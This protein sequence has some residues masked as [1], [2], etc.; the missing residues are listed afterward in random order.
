[1]AT[2]FLTPDFDVDFIIGMWAVAFFRIESF[3]CG[4]ADEMP[5]QGVQVTD[6]DLRS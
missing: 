5:L 4:L 6:E 1:M 3:G 2:F